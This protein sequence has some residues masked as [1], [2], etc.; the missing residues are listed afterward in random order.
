MEFEYQT[1]K[2]ILNVC[3]EIAEHIAR[4]TE[5]A[6]RRGYQHGALNGH[7]LKMQ[8][9]KWRLMLNGSKLSFA[10]PPP[11][12][13]YKYPCSSVE[14]LVMEAPFSSELVHQLCWMSQK[15]AG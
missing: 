12:A 9:Y 5:Q 7:G 13:F 8:V 10:E 14:R 15:E 6:Y 2:Q 3:P 11:G 1:A 4:C